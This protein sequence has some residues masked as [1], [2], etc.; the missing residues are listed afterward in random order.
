MAD[1]DEIQVQIED[2][3]HTADG[4]TDTPRNPDGTFKAAEVDPADDLA[5]QFEE[6]RKESDRLRREATEARQEAARARQEAQSARG[7]QTE[8]EY[9][10]VATRIA[11]AQ[12]DATAAEAEYTRAYEAGDGAAMAA[13]QRKIAKAE[14]LAV[15]LDEAKADIEVRRAAKPEDQPQ[16]RTEAPPE[17]RR[18][19]PVDDLLAKCTPATRK[20]LTEHRDYAE[21]IATNANGGDDQRGYDAAAAHADA[22]RN[23]LREDTP[24]YFEHVETY[25][26]LR[27]QPTKSSGNGAA[28]PATPAAKPRRQSVPVAP[29]H[30]SS[31]G[32]NGGGDTVTLSKS[33]A[34]A[35]T[36]GT[37]QWN[38]PDPTGK[39]RWKLGDPIGRQ[40]FARRKREMIKQGVYDRTYVEQ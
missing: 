25:L 24:E 6:Q 14:A 5:A 17:A 9:E 38:Y 13:A 8:S 40:E 29:V 15:R 21:G 1:D 19:D 4:A 35:A 12:A 3:T 22:K 11:S 16:R 30:Q 20:W 2:D 37:H 23:R 31:G 27:D 26:G 39:N 18:V 7:E 10:T 34:L 28:K 36:D 32:T 33:E